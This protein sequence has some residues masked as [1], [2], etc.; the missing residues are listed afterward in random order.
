M[1]NTSGA[2]SSTSSEG[3][4]PATKKLTKTAFVLSLPLTTPARDIVQKAKAAGLTLNEHYVHTIRSAAKAKGTSKPT[5]AK[6]AAKPAPKKAAPAKPAAAKAAP[7]K[8][9]PAKPAAAAPASAA[10]KRSKGPKPTKREFIMSFGAEVPAN[11]IIARAREQGI[12]VA[13]NTI[14]KV[15]M[16]ARRGTGAPAPAAAAPAAAPAAARRKP[17][18]PAKAAAPA[19]KAVV[20]A[21]PAVSKADANVA[22]Q[23]VNIALDMGLGRAI[24]T[25]EEVRAKIEKLV[26]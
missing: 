6:P 23:L 25:L 4:A 3:G 11:E 24:K 16:Q 8:A 13:A 19:P 7:K 14:Y 2:P 15:R 17:G 21:A 18:R 20:V 10:S 1:Q 26:G 9:A 5:K 12:S 22:R